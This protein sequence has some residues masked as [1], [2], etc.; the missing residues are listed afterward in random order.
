MTAERGFSLLEVLVA[1]A[2]FSMGAL[3]LLNVVGEGARNQSAAD[4]RAL[5]R[6]IAENRMVEVMAADVPPSP[7][8]ASGEEEA[9]TRRFAWDQSVA[10]TENPAILR[11]DVR[12]RRIEG[13]QTLAELTTFRAAR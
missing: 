6:I 12:V 13:T 4:A 10:P 11:I 9:M 3:A 7:G 8:L 2:V 1:L 5:A